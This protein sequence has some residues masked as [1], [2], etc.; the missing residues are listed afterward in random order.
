MYKALLLILVASTF[1]R[2]TPAGADTADTLENY[3]GYTIVAS[4]TIVGYRDKDGKSSDDFEGCDFDR[5]IR[6]DDGTTLTCSGYD[7]T[8]AYRPTALIL[9]KSSEFQGRKTAQAVMIVE[10]DAYDMELIFLR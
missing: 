7:Y 9:M 5:K 1:F 8:Y 2:T 6:F 3:V 4:K 10:D